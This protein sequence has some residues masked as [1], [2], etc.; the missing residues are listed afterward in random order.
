VDMVDKLAAQATSLGRSA[1]T[2]HVEVGM[3][4]TSTSNGAHA[5]PKAS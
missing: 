5:A 4:G 3:C 2:D 1:H